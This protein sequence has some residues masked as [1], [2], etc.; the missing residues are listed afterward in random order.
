MP[1]LSIII[2]NWNSKDFLRKCLQSIYTCTRE[3]SFEI[4]VVDGASFDGCGEMLAREFPDVRFIQS[5]KNIGFARANNLGFE[6]SHG[7]EILFLNPDTEI[8]GDAI[9]VLH[10]FLKK[11]GCRDCGR[12]AA[13]HRWQHTNHVHPGVPNDFEPVFG[14]GKL[15]LWIPQPCL[16]GHCAV[17]FRESATGGSPSNFRC[18]P[19]VAEVGVPENWPVQ[20]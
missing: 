14:Y 12:E 5:E 9:N 13:E 10:T 4:I 15:A 8:I 20:R 7:E 11:T 18:L 2:V 16:L 3:I 6:Q 17:I 1:Q 19:D